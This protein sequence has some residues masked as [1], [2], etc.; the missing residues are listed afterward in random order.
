MK[1][2]VIIIYFLNTPLFSFYISD[3]VTV[4]NLLFQKACY[5]WCRWTVFLVFSMKSTSEWKGVA[6]NRC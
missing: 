2:M 5:Y 6:Y 3:L 4:D 1:W